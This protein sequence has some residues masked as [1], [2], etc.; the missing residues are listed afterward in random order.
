ML[1]VVM[2]GWRAGLAC[3]GG[4]ALLMAGFWLGRTTATPQGIIAPPVMDADAEGLRAELTGAR[5]RGRE[6]AAQVAWLQAQLA[7][8]GQDAASADEATAAAEAAAGEAPESD[9]APGEQ[10]EPRESWFD[11]R[12]LR[13]L[14][15]PETEV[16][17]LQSLFNE[18]EM[19]RVELLHQAEREGW[20]DKRRLW[21][22]MV[23]FQVGLREEIGDEDYD[24]MLYATG[25]KNR[26]VMGEL[27]DDSPAE[28]YG[29]EAGDVVV[30]YDGQK[31]YH[32]RE[33]RR[34]TA[35]GER[36]DW[37]TV[38]VLREGEFVRVRAQRGPLGVKLRPARI[39]PEALW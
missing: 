32:G 26:V 8:I 7:R 16:A 15:L 17:R 37:V 35:Q 11:A 36:G 34:A 9:T 10:P 38:D 22:E 18:Y 25:R 30:G 19:E 27:L 3:S 39:L 13:D 5:E 2:S 20:A 23:Q 31:V 4:L 28:R 6:L 24:L 14:G 21:D 29:F 33:L 1:G 12:E